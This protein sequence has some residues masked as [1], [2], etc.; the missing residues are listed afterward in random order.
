MATNPFPV[1]GQPVFDS[2]G[3][4]VGVYSQPIGLSEAS[5]FDPL[6]Q[7]V[8]PTNTGDTG[9]TQDTSTPPI[10]GTNNPETGGSTDLGAVINNAINAGFAA[11]QLASLPR[12][13][14]RTVTTTVGGT[15][16]R[17]GPQ[18]LVGGIF[19]GTPQQQN[20]LI[21]LIILVLAGILI[22]KAVK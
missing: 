21:I 7:L 20:Q 3:S 8:D 15:Q 18:S 11:W 5:V 12:G 9:A 2:G 10:A 14:P 4:L 22:Y 16:V 13:T 19:G 17:T 1:F 6:T